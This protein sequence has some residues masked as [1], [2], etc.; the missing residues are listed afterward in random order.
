[1]FLCLLHDK[2]H[3]SY[4]CKVLCLYVMLSLSSQVVDNVTTILLK[5]YVAA[6]LCV[7][8]WVLVNVCPKY[9]ADAGLNLKMPSLTPRDL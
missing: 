4:E 2:S 7:K 6:F 9:H 1:M 3:S 8:Q 5:I